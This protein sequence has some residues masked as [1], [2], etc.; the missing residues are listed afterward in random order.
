MITSTRI[1][2]HMVNN[3]DHKLD[4]IFHALSDPT[5]RAMLTRLVQ[6]HCKVSELP[7]PQ[8]VSK[9]AISKHLNILHRANLVEKQKDGRITRCSPSPNS[10]DPVLHLLEELGVFW[11]DQL[12]S[13]ERY[14]KEDFSKET[15]NANNKGSNSKTRNKKGNIR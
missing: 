15:K 12:G 2:N 13:L 3:Y 1:V 4:N 7:N 8:K 9:A 5:R 11:R 6:G 14:F 10:L